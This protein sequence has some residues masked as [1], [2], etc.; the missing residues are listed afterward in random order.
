MTSA[1][2]ESVF[3]LLKTASSCYTGYVPQ[4]FAG[5][6]PDFKDDVIISAAP[7]STSASVSAAEPVPAAVSVS[8]PAQNPAPET[9]PSEKIQNQIQPQKTVP[10]TLDT[11]FEKVRNCS[12]CILSRNR[13]NPVFGEGVA[14][15][16]VLVI[17]DSPEENDTTTGRIF[18][19]E[20]GA[21]LDKMLSAISL[22]RTTNTYVANLVKCPTSMG[23]FP[24]N[25]EISSCTGFLQAQI[26][27]LKPKYILAMGRT[28]T[29]ALLKSGQGMNVLHGKWFEYNGIPL[30]PTY[31][32]SEL[33]RDVNLKRPAWEDLKMFKK[34]LMNKNLLP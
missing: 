13:K 7:L 28:S 14:F 8:A 4:D 10:L 30:M 21:L 17:G 24:M 33:L 2:K 34:E 32:P 22:S 31:H 6:T 27:I 23:R 16:L 25:D 3:N 9:A 18:S 29:Q 15:P 12:N 26:H 5:E 20:S 11:L 1:E 19:G